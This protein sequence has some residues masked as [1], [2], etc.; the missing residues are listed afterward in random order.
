MYAFAVSLILIGM[1]LT[2]AVRSVL[3]KMFYQL[4][5]QS[6]LFVT[7]IYLLGQSLSLIVYY[8]SSKIQ[9]HRHQDQ[10]PSTANNNNS[11][12]D[13]SSEFCEYQEYELGSYLQKVRRDDLEDV[14]TARVLS[15]YAYQSFLAE[16]LR[17]SPEGDEGE[18]GMFLPVT[19]EGDFRSAPP[20][21]P[22]LPRQG[23][24]TGLTVRSHDAVKWVHRIPWY[25]K[26]VLPGFCN[27]CNAGMR[28]ASLLFVSA[29]VAEILISGL[30][31]VLS[32]CVAR[33]IRRRLVSKTRWYGVALVTI[34]LVVV[35]LSNAF[36]PNS[37]SSI[38]SSSSSGNNNNN[39]LLG[40]LLIV[41]QCVMSVTQDM[42]E[43]LFIDEAGFP[44]TLLLGMEGLFGLCFGLLLYYPLAHMI[45]EN[46]S[47]TWTTL[48]TS[49]LNQHCA[50]TL[51]L[52]FTVT[53]IFNIMATA[54]TSS[55][56]RNVWKNCRTILVWLISLAIYYVSGNQS[57]GEA[58]LIPDS[59]AILAGFFI[60]LA[61]IYVYYD[62][63]WFGRIK[64]EWKVPMNVVTTV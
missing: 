53:G 41:G 42:A 40:N 15:G 48:T 1:I 37:S 43:E 16:T 9:Q 36:G 34:G 20:P 63:N 45:G 23:S 54:V 62:V 57:L 12:N 58:W 64:L 25:W 4:G 10:L 49:T 19:D 17:E 52:L 39:V 14:D 31:L 6:P 11:N 60:M 22:T 59:F 61:G 27:L 44:A 56:T 32:V 30:E 5:F 33:L 26:P 38:G 51:T 18:G 13:R 3:V 47:D 8:I 21:R 28:W 35:G 2:G 29:S 24:R 7:M 46:V 55:M 50:V